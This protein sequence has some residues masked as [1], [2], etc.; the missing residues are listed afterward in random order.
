MASKV[1]KDKQLLEKQKL[2]TKDAVLFSQQNGLTDHWLAFLKK[3]EVED[4]AKFAKELPV[5][6][7]KEKRN[8]SDSEETERD[9][10]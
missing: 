5:N 6:L 2:R 3:L 8:D 9:D 10:T 4:R 7:I 1:D